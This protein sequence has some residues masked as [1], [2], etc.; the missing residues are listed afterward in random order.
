VPQRVIRSRTIHYF[1]EA[2]T[3][4]C[5]WS[6]RQLDYPTL[7]SGSQMSK[8]SHR[9]AQLIFC[10][11]AVSLVAALGQTTSAGT[12][13][14]TDWTTAS[15]GVPGSAFGSLSLGGT[16][17]VSYSG[18]VAF[19]QINDAG[20]NWWIPGSTYTSATVSN[21][22][23]GTDIIALSGA[24]P[25]LVDTITFSRPVTDPIMTIFSLGSPTITSELTFDV[26]FTILSSGPNAFFGFV[27]LNELPGNVL[28]GNEGNGTIEF[29]GTYSQISWTDDTFE[30]WHGFTIGAPESQSVPEPSSAVLMAL[31]AGGVLYYWRKRKISYAF[32]N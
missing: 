32:G 24:N 14:W 29:T 27:S 5:L 12:I 28:Q 9:F 3:Q 18:E 22:P 8:I 1:S 20:T 13:S 15:D 25:S 21:A 11:S 17:S 26:P 2:V 31:G 30:F 16:V 4:L 7:R 10:L 19:A 23:S 6:E